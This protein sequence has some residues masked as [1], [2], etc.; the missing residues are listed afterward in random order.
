[1]GNAFAFQH[2]LRLSKGTSLDRP[3]H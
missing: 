3:I 2:R 1:V